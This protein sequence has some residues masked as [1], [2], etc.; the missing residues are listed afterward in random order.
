MKLDE[1]RIREIASNITSKA[2]DF[3][4]REGMKKKDERLPKRLLEEPL[5]DS[6][7]IFPKAEFEKMLSDYYM[8]KKWSEPPSGDF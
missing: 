1:R 4:L 3:N 7:K 2:R 5:E 8:L 6:R